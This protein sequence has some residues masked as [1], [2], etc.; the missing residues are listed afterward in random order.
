M[1]RRITRAYTRTFR[2]WD[3]TNTLIYEKEKELEASRT[4]R[5]SLFQ[6]KP[7]DLAAGPYQAS[8]SIDGEEVCSTKFEVV[9]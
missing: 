6:F 5:V 3:R 2:L 4:G 7:G 8:W 1:R 9:E